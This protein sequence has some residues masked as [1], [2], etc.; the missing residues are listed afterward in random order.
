MSNKMTIKKKVDAR[1]LPSRRGIILIAILAVAILV[2]NLVVFSYSWFTP[3]SVTGKGLSMDDQIAVRSENCTFETYQGVVVTE[4]MVKGLNGYNAN[5]YKD[6]YIDQIKYNDVKISDN[7]EITI[8]HATTDSETG[9]TIPGRVYFRTNIQNQDTKY[10]SVVSLYHHQMPAGL[11]V[12][13]TYPSNTY[14]YNESAYNDFFIIRNAYVKV[15]D[16]NDA[17][18]PGLLQ[19]EWFVENSSNTDKKIRVTRQTVG[20]TSTEWLY[21]MYN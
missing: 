15:K 2:V 12:A 1:R 17:D 20:S 11:A 8:P 3:S 18:G 5:D 10:S 14:Y 13:V 16:Q 9:K 6:Y 21:L 19:V 7:V 4:D